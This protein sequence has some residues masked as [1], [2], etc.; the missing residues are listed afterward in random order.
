MQYKSSISWIVTQQSST[1]DSSPIF[2][3]ENNSI[4]IH[5]KIWMAYLEPVFLWAWALLYINKTNSNSATSQSY[6]IIMIIKDA[7]R[8]HEVQQRHDALKRE[9]HWTLNSAVAR[10]GCDTVLDWAALLRA[11]GW[12]LTCFVLPEHNNAEIHPSCK[13][14]QLVLE[15]PDRSHLL[16]C[17]PQ[18][19]QWRESGPRPLHLQGQ[20]GWGIEQPGLV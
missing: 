8:L 12:M 5:L 16:P 6:H 19:N 3:I 1:R 9:R 13:L 17:T 4:F 2:M 15:T 7:F 20:V 18:G 11:R 14:M 10:D